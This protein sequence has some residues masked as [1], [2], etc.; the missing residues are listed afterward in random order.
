MEVL[1]T[2]C[3]V[4]LLDNSS[5]NITPTSNYAAMLRNVSLFIVDEA[6]MVPLHAF[7]AIDRLLRDITGIDTSFGGK[8]FLWGDDF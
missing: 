3:S 4:P 5:C 1:C 6:S 7:N 2:V 8:P